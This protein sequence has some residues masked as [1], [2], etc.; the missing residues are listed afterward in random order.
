LLLFLELAD[1]IVDLI[2]LGHDG[3]EWLVGGPQGVD[4]TAVFGEFVNDVVVFGEH[5]RGFLRLD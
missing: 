5:G 2:V 1:F 4:Q 3:V